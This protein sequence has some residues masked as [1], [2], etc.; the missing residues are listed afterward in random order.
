MS[1]KKASIFTVFLSTLILVS[2]SQT[3][4][5][6]YPSRNEEPIP[7]RYQPTHEAKTR[8]TFQDRVDHQKTS[9]DRHYP[10]RPDKPRIGTPYPE[11]QYP[12]ASRPGPETP[13]VR[14]PQDDNRY[15]T[16]APLFVIMGGYKSCQYELES[17]SEDGENI[18]SA[19][20]TFE[21]SHDDRSW[22]NDEAPW[23]IPSMEVTEDTSHSEISSLKSRISANRNDHDRKVFHLFFKAF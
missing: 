14:P 22:S 6:H 1:L 11:P 19:F 13:T 12:D 2:C 9:P 4:S 17:V 5:K 18:F 3:E 15:A 7:G 23:N 10:K 8:T 20:F 16:P 21:T